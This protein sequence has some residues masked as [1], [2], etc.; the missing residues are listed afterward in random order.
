MD[1]PC[2]NTRCMEAAPAWTNSALR[3]EVFTFAPIPHSD[4]SGKSKPPLRMRFTPDGFSVE[5]AT[6]RTLSRY[7]SPGPSR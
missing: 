5:P 3:A 6:I 2:V 1:P 7:T 4:P